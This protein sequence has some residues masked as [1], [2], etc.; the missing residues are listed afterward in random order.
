MKIFFLIIIFIII[1]NLNTKE[2]YINYNKKSNETIFVSIPSY[3]DEECS[4][5]LDNLFKQAKNPEQI[6]VGVFTQNKLKTE[7]C[8]INKYKNNI[9]YL[10]INYKK[11]AGPLYA[12]VQ[13]INKLY[14]NEKYFLMIDAHSTFVKNWDEKFKK[15]LNFLKKK[16]IN[17]PIISS[18]PNPT[19][20][21]EN[22]QNNKDISF[23]CN[24]NSG[25]DFPRAMQAYFKPNGKFYKSYFIAAGCLFTYGI[26]FK[27]IKFDPNLK[28]IFNGEEILFAILAYTNGWDIYTP[29]YN[30]IFHK[31]GIDTVNKPSWFTDN[32]KNKTFSK[33]EKESY[34]KLKKIIYD[35]I[36]SNSYKYGIGNKRSLE[37]FWKKIGYNR[38]ESTFEKKWT[39]ESKNNLCNKQKIIE[40][41]F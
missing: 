1:Y 13:I 6:Y 29:A 40:Y 32:N 27:E 5:T 41:K 11:A 36:F 39:E 22:E 20:N 12:R 10:H 19:K 28:H 38:Y 25:N 14:K 31:Y 2:N 9:R 21:N 8:K 24:I 16:G 15:Q 26:F 7:S 34:E 3:R 17:K 33:K 37:S 30:L 18:Y 4:I 35:P 23:I